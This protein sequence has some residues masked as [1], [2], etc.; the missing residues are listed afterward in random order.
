MKHIYLDFWIKNTV[1]VVVL[2]S[3]SS[4]V[5]FLTKEGKNVKVTHSV[6][7]IE[8]YNCDYISS[9]EHTTSWAMG[10]AQLLKYTKNY[11][12]ANGGDTTVIT[13]LIRP[14][15]GNWEATVFFDYYNCKNER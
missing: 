6:K 13:Q 1:L 14:E 11:A 12:S 3:L 5:T 8:K 15:F 2:F 10:T 4:C 7:Y 9:Q